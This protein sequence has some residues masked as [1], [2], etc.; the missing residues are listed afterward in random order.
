MKPFVETDIKAEGFVFFRDFKKILK[1]MGTMFSNDE[2]KFLAKPFLLEE[3]QEREREGADSR[4]HVDQ[5]R[6]NKLGGLL[7]SSMKLNGTFDKFM[8]KHHFKEPIQRKHEPLYANIERINDESAVDYSGFVEELSR[9]LDEYVEQKGGL[10]LSTSFAAGNDKRLPWIIKEFE[11]VDLLLT[12]LEAMNSTNRRKTLITLQYSLENADMQQTGE[13]DGFAV[14]SSLLNAGFK[15]QRYSRV[16]LLKAAESYGGKLDYHRLIVTLLQTAVNW[17]Q[18]ERTLIF[19]ILRS[20]GN[21]IEDRRLWLAKMKKELMERVARQKIKS[22]VRYFSSSSSTARGSGGRAALSEDPENEILHMPIPPTIF[23]HVLRDLNTQL[24]PEEEATLLDCLD[25]ER[26]A[27]LHIRKLFKVSS[28]SL[29]RGREREDEEEFHQQ[30]KIHSLLWKE[31]D[32]NENDSHS[33]GGGEDSLPMIDYYSFVKFVSRHCG[34]WTDSKPQLSNLLQKIVASLLHPLP[35]VQELFSLFVSF[36]EN[37]NGFISMRSFLV[38]CHRSRFFANV[39]EAI[40][41]ELGNTLVLDGVGEIQYRLFIVQLRGIYMKVMAER[42]EAASS[43]SANGSIIH[44]L[45]ENATDSETQSLTPLRNY[46]VSTLQLDSLQSLVI[47][48]K[49]FQRLLREFSIVY[50]STEF[51]SL[52]LEIAVD[53]QTNS[54]AN[55]FQLEEEFQEDEEEFR[56]RR[57]RGRGAKGERGE[58][59]KMIDIPRLM[60]LLMSARLPWYQRNLPLTKKLLHSLNKLSKE[61]E[62]ENDSFLASATTNHMT[63]RQLE[64]SNTKVLNRIISRINAFALEDLEDQEEGG[65]G[66]AARR[67]GAGK[68]DIHDILQTNDSVSSSSYQKGRL[69]EWN[70]FD[71]IIKSMGILLTP[72]EIRFLC[73]SSDPNPECNRVNPYL[74]L[75]LLHIYDSTN[76]NSSGRREGTTTVAGEGEELNEAALFALNHFQTLLWRAKDV[77]FASLFKDSDKRTAVA[78]KSFE[79]EFGTSFLTDPDFHTAV[80]GKTSVSSS[81][82]KTK[83]MNRY[84]D[85]SSNNNDQ[86]K[87]DIRNIFRG[88]DYLGNGF[89]DLKDFLLIL[90]LLNITISSDL[91]KDIPF[92]NFNHELVNYPKLL[93]YLLDTKHLSKHQRFHLQSSSGLRMDEDEE[94]EERDGEYDDDNYYNEGRRTKGKGR[95]THSDKKQISSS[96]AHNSEV[97]P[98]SL[99]LLVN[100]IRTNISIFISNNHSMEEAW[101]ELLKIFSQFDKMER[102]FIPSREFLLAISVLLTSSLSSSSSDRFVPKYTPPN[103]E[104]L[105]SK[106]EWDEILCYFRIEDD[107]NDRDSFS[108]S[109]T[110]R[111]NRNNTINREGMKINYLL[112]CEMV[113][114]IKEI[115]KKLIE[116]QKYVHNKGKLREKMDTMKSSSSSLQSSHYRS[117]DERDEAGLEN[118]LNEL[119]RDQQREFLSGR[120]PLMKKQNQRSP[121][122]KKQSSSTTTTMTT[123]RTTNSHSSISPGKRSSSSSSR[124]AVEDDPIARRFQQLNEKYHPSS[125]RSPPQRG[126]RGSDNGRGVPDYLRSASRTQGAT[127]R[128]GGAFFQRNKENS[129]HHHNNSSTTTPQRISRGGGSFSS[130]YNKSMTVDGTTISRNDINERK[131]EMI[132]EKLQQEQPQQQN[133]LSRKQLYDASH[134]R[135][136]NAL[137]TGKTVRFNWTN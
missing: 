42:Q 102:N 100:R 30:K 66:R 64:S 23:L 37:Q 101:M 17:S 3:E 116:L 22:K 75:D 60:K 19:K 11:L 62:R 86:W 4:S 47:S 7:S 85:N 131:R 115:E 118:Y 108:S 133:G 91:L 114:N 73:D 46:L 6:S 57:G 61:R 93:D 111:G 67:R 13:L 12:Q 104:L 33:L 51:E 5:I 103:D 99:Q 53:Y 34:S 45:L 96:I 49:E 74:L 105:F 21:T 92:V 8:D 14:L 110:N 24:L 129:N 58:V 43:D 83:M 127:S 134:A 29:M 90:R 94:Q 50:Q 39:D 35:C 82:K 106:Q 44:Q 97:I 77:A 84:D 48:L 132:R 63:S 123:G 71:Y 95:Q 89:I 135:G 136:G 88:F 121:L 113:L 38:A 36:D 26:L 2:Y 78:K 32:E 18:T 40:I 41:E 120:T 80:H 68:E 122:H 20:M 69:I 79:K 81:P 15:L 16:Q 56:T 10:P 28:S 119:Q 130:S 98:R 70:I 54:S 76:N 52:L 59:I 107:E 109:L 31:D 1:E 137:G 65:T 87:L 117:S 27:K 126:E 112:F 125:S 25:T 9:L 72:H 124:L 55:D 128:D